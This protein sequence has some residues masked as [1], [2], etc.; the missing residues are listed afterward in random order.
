MIYWNYYKN[1]K[2]CLMEHSAPGKRSSRLRIRRGWEA[3]MFATLPSTKD[4]WGN[5]QN[6][7]WVFST[8]IIPRG[9]ILSIMDIPIV[10]ST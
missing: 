8:I 1:P 4:T 7:G 9:G 5:V 2:S 10:C 3:N 6:R